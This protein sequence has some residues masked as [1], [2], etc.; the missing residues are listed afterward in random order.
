[1]P[2]KFT[3]LLDE[4]RAV[5]GAKL[6]DALLPLLLFMIANTF[7][8][9]Q[10]AMWSALA[11]SILLGIR[12]LYRKESLTYSLL[13][14]FSVLLAIGLVTLLGRSESFFLPG[15]LSSGVTV[16]LCILSLL[17]GRPL[18]AWSSF[19]ARRWEIAWYWHPR[20]R[21]A[22]TETTLLWTI[23]FG[24]KFWWQLRLFQVGDAQGLA[25]VQP[26]TGFPAMVL[27]L[28]ITYIY[29]TWRL[30]NLQGPSVDEFKQKLPAPWLG[31]QH[32]F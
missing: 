1:M 27:L 29:G 8:G 5:L 26:L 31:Q 24:A 28:V 6:V 3:E 25:W 30:R 15:V 9:L 18:T 4:F 23:F 17:L 21:P 22:Y 16:G 7:W 20:V 2:P 11:S 12:R 10:V 32:G 19:I 13:G 14:V